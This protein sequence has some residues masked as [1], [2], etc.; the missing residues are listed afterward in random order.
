VLDSRSVD[1]TATFA[2]FI[3][4]KLF[5]TITAYVPGPYSEQYTFTSSLVVQLL[6]SLSP[7]VQKLMRETPPAMIAVGAE[8][9]SA[10]VRNDEPALR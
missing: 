10:S 5:G 6:K 2:F 8:L 4:D 7:E 9:K 3:G 1:R